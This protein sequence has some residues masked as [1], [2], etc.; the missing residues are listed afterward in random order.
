MTGTSGSGTSGDAATA[1]TMMRVVTARIMSSPAARRSAGRRLIPGRDQHAAPCMARFCSDTACII[2]ELPSLCEDESMLL[3]AYESP[4][5]EGVT[6]LTRPGGLQ[7]AGRHRPCARLVV[8]LSGSG[9]LLPTFSYRLPSFFIQIM[10]KSTQST[11]KISFYYHLG[12]KPRV[13]H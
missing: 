3:L 8:Q 12:K 4:C 2:V 1:R 10:T 13:K 6:E 5:L 11:E 7:R 9:Q